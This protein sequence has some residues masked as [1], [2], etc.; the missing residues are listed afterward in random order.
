MSNLGIDAG[1]KYKVK[2]LVQIKNPVT[3]HYALIDQTTGRLLA[4]KKSKGA[5][6]NIMI[7]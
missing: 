1:H 5:Y 4:H 7:V 3:K 6:K 2:N